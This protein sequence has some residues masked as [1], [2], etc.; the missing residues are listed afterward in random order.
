MLSTGF[1]SLTTPQGTIGRVRRRSGGALELAARRRFAEG[2]G[3]VDVESA[4][5]PA[6][7][8]AAIEA[9]GG[10]AGALEQA[11]DW[12]N[13]KFDSTHL[14][15]T[16]AG[17]FA[18]AGLGL[19]AGAAVNAIGSLNDKQIQNAIEKGNFN[20]KGELIGTGLFGET[21]AI[22]PG[23]GPIG[24]SS[25]R[26]D[27][28]ESD[29][30]RG[31]FDDYAPQ[32]TTQTDTTTPGQGTPSKVYDPTTG[33]FKD[34]LIT[35]DGKRTNLDGTPLWGMADGGSVSG[36]IDGETGGRADKVE[37]DLPPGSYII[38]ATE[39]SARGDGN[40]SAGA[41]E[42]ARDLGIKLGRLPTV[43]GGP[44]KARIAHGEV[45]VAPGDVRRN[46]GAGALDRYVM[47]LRQQHINKLKSLP[48][49][50]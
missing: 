42:M 28:S 31:S 16:I 15:G 29:A 5:N 30:N 25:M 35:A 49:P 41:L 50:Q 43:R 37:A 24:T 2:G 14:G 32:P 21:V 38:P 27:G 10:Q 20:E 34:I 13:S 23:P 40:T 18:P 33:G 3:T 26:S 22:G 45:Y 9:M 47:Q 1:K 39:V 48:E 36:L 8:A 44:V 11:G 6:A 46:G 19:V 12:I 4:G 17:A 7:E